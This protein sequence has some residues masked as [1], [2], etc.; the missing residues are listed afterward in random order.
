LGTE[1]LEAHHARVTAA[2][3]EIPSANAAQVSAVLSGQ[4]GGSIAL[5]E[6]C[7]DA[8]A[9]LQAST[10]T[11]AGFTETGADSLD[12]TVASRRPTRCA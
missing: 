2:L 12:L 11:Q 8:F 7:D 5:A 3:S 6:A 4:G 1:A 9:R 10:S